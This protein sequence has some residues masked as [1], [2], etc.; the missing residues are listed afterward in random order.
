MEK[1]SFNLGGW[2][3]AK[4]KILIIKGSEWEG[5]WKNKGGMTGNDRAKRPPYIQVGDSISWD[6]WIGKAV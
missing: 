4:Q 1:V 6:E 5:R 2:E 3:A